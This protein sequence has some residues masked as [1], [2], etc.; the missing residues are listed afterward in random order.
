[1]AG[2]IWNNQDIPPYQ[3]LRIL[4]EPWG[5]R[6][7]T[8]MIQLES[9]GMVTIVPGKDHPRVLIEEWLPAAAIG[10]ECIR[11]RSTGQQPPDKRFHVWWQDVP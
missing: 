6:I 10:V 9:K 7:E 3:S 5:G 2:K 4:W 1:M 11:E 8:A